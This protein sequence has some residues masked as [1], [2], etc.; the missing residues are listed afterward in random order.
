MP[1]SQDCDG[2]A[3]NL[4]QDAIFVASP[5]E[6]P[7]PDFL[8]DILRFRRQGSPFGMIFERVRLDHE[9]RKPT[10]TGLGCPLVMEPFQHRLDLGFRIV[11]NTTR[12]ALLFA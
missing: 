4:E 7:F 1:H 3:A 6:Q 9:L 2:L 11:A 10:A 5:A 12:Y 8:A